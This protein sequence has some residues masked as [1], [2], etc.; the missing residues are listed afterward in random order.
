MVNT[1]YFSL[2]GGCMSLFQKLCF[3]DR[4]SFATVSW[5]VVE[6]SNHTTIFI[7]KTPEVIASGSNFDDKII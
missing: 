3:Q 6:K 4:E 2:C 5:S 7:S 1:F